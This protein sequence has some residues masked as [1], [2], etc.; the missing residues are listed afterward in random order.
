MRHK[1]NAN[2]VSKIPCVKINDML[3]MRRFFSIH[4]N[5]TRCTEYFLTVLIINTIFS[6]DVVSRFLFVRNKDNLQLLRLPST[7]A[8][9]TNQL[10]IEESMMRNYGIKRHKFA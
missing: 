9:F 10:E 7:S 8:I 3:I 5:E 2:S 6:L 1:L 4:A